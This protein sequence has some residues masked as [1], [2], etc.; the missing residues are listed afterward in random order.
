MLFPLPYET[1]SLE[2]IDKDFFNCYI[3]GIISCRVVFVANLQ[4]CSLKQHIALS[5]KNMNNES[6]EYFRGNKQEIENEKKRKHALMS[7]FPK[8]LGTTDRTKYILVDDDK[9][10]QEG[11]EIIQK[12]KGP[13]TTSI[14]SFVNNKKEV[15]F[16]ICKKN[17]TYLNPKKEAVYETKILKSLFDFDN[18]AAE[19]KNNPFN[20]NSHSLGLG[21]VTCCKPRKATARNDSLGLES[22]NIENVADSLKTANKNYNTNTV[23]NNATI[24]K[25][26]KQPG[27]YGGNPGRDYTEELRKVKQNLPPIAVSILNNSGIEIVV[28]KNMHS[29]TE[30]GKIIK[31]NGRYFADKKKIYL[32]SKHVNEYTMFSEAVHVVQDHLGMIGIGKSNLEF[33]EHVIKDLYYSQKRRKLY[34]DDGYDEHSA[35]KDNEYIYLMELAF[36]ENG[37]LNLNKFLIGINNFIN[38]FQKEYL[39]SDSYQTPAVKDFNYNWIE[40]LQIFGIEYK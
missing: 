11:F 36:D 10:Q 20:T 5:Q 3:S 33:Q 17:S 14:E 19:E 26:D 25:L 8:V 34:G 29:V 23:S 2:T 32:D 4:P 21:T 13:Q 31:R 6:I 7:Y 24:A 15:D 28:L 37:V 39:P 22:R 30:N 40:L 12:H 18:N 1:L 27:L 35:S 38:S 9:L 16:E